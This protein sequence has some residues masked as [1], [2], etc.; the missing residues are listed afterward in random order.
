MLLG[1]D[2]NVTIKHSPAFERAKELLRKKA[3]A[4]KK[5]LD[6]RYQDMA[7][8]AETEQ[9]RHDR[10]YNDPSAWHKL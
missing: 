9:E 8:F 7:E 3:A 6:E 1:E 2:V 4:R 5:M 10:V